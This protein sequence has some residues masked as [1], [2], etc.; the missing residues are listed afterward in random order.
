MRPSVILNPNAGR[1]LRIF[2]P[3]ALLDDFAVVQGDPE[4]GASVLVRDSSGAMIGR[5]FTTRA[6]RSR[7]GCSPGAKS[8]SM[9]D[10]SVDA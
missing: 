10:G 2:Y 8:A 1:M 7:Y 6:P 4:P 3:W 9:L 5:R